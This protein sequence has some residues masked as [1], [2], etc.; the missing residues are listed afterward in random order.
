MSAFILSIGTHHF[1]LK[2]AAIAANMRDVL[3]DAPMVEA[4]ALQHGRLAW[5]T[6]TNDGIP[7]SVRE[8]MDVVGS[9]ATSH[10]VTSPAAEAV[11][12]EPRRS[13]TRTHKILIEAG[14]VS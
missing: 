2:S 9:V 4:I 1:V 6:V 7:I 5:R 10:L 13:F 8:I 3:R 11:L 12:G 14:R